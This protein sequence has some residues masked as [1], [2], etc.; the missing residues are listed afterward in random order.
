[1]KR[2]GLLFTSHSGGDS[3]YYRKKR[4]AER[5]AGHALTNAEFERD[6]YQQ[7]GQFNDGHRN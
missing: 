5:E 1:M 6:H 7:G 3:G 4:A 2:D